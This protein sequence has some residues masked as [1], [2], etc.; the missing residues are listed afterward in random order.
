MKHV[1]SEIL[2][3]AV[4]VGATLAQTLGVEAYRAGERAEVLMNQR[5]TS[6]KDTIVV[7]DT[8]DYDDEGFFFGEEMQED[9][10]PKITARDTMKV[11]DSLK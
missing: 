7:E 6:P 1:W 10:M 8:T 11:P 4:I 9:T 5:F 3:P 2:V